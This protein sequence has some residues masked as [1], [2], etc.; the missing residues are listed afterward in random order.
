[1][2][3]LQQLRDVHLPAS[4]SWWP[5]A[6]GWWLVALIVCA[7]LVFVWVHWRRRRQRRKP[8]HVART[9]LARLAEARCAHTLDATGFADACSALIKRLHIHALGHGSL[10]AASG[11]DWLDAL[12]TPGLDADQRQVVREALGANRFRRDF[13]TDPDKLEPATR[14]LIRQLEAGV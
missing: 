3:A 11:D 9:E 10:A 7:A 1:M 5:P 14:A 2:D 6:P 12:D 4:P 13:T 8:L